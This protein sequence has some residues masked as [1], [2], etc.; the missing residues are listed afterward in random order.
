MRMFKAKKRK[1]K[2]RGGYQHIN[3]GGETFVTFVL[4]L[5]MRPKIHYH[6]QYLDAL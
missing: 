4:I 3:K 5:K 2:K 6:I 1:E